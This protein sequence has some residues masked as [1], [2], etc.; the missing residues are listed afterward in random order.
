MWD[1]MELVSFYQGQES[2]VKWDISSSSVSLIETAS[3]FNLHP[4]HKN[5]QDKFFF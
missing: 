1:H 3:V 4:F 5:W 2:A